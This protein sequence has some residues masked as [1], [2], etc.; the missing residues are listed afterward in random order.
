MAHKRKTL[1][2][3]SLNRHFSI[4]IVK[5]LHLYARHKN[6]DT[7]FIDFLVMTHVRN[8][9]IIQST[10]KLHFLMFINF[11]HLMNEHI[12]IDLLER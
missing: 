2:I 3:S 11:K 5:L 8:C 9:I 10:H 1:W 6:E 12:S 7:L 4:S